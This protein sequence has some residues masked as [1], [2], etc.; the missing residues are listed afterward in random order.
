[1][2]MADQLYIPRKALPSGLV[3][4]LTRLAAFQNPAFYAAQALR[5]ATHDKPRIISCAELTADHV[6]LPRG[7]FDVAMD[8]F[9]SLGVTVDIDDRRVSGAA[10]DVSFDRSRRRRSMRSFRMISACSPRPRPSERRW[11]RRV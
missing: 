10:I 7:C 9:A 6:A 3:A 4:R 8:L 11:S 1:M 5:L 2:V